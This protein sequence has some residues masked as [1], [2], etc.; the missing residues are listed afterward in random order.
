MDSTGEK[1]LESVLVFT[2]LKIE[3]GWQLH[4]IDSKVFRQHQEK[5]DKNTLEKA[6]DEIGLLN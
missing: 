2:A 4:R 5:E 3:F 1:T 6:V